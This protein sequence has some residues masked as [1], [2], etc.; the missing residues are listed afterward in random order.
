[1]SKNNVIDPG[2]LLSQSKEIY[3][4]LNNESDIA[5]VLIATSFI[6]TTLDSLLRYTFIKSRVTEKVLNSNSGVLGTFSA[7]CDTGYCLGILDKDIY[8][9]LIKLGEIRN[10]FAH[11][12]LETHF[13]NSDIKTLCAQLIRTKDIIDGHR[14][15]DNYEDIKKSFEIPRNSFIVTVVMII[16]LL[17]LKGLSMKV[18]R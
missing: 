3:K 14:E 2:D 5:V 10:I 18:K 12:H 1:M 13:N 17:L 8:K 4:D 11:N 9:D 7:K 15:S 16:N 6:D